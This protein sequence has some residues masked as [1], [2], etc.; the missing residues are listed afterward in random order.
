[1]T[2]QTRLNCRSLTNHHLNTKNAD[3]TPIPPLGTAFEITKGVW[4]KYEWKINYHYSRHCREDLQSP[5]LGGK[6]EGGKPHYNVMDL[7]IP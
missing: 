2:P 1:M 6:E 5:T 7:K 3:A 4:S